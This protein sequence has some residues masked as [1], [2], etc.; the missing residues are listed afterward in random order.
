M[1]KHVKKENCCL[2]NSLTLIFFFTDHY[3]IFCDIRFYSLKCDFIKASTFLCHISCA[4][5]MFHTFFLEIIMQLL[6]L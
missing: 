2:K 1:D 6:T 4:R 5:L 3:L